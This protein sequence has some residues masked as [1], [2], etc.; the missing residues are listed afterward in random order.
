MECCNGN[1]EKPLWHHLLAPRDSILYWSW[2]LAETND[3]KALAL[4]E[5]VAEHIG[6]AMLRS[7]ADVEALLQLDAIAEEEPLPTSHEYGSAGYCLEGCRPLSAGAPPCA[8]EFRNMLQTGSQY[9]R[10]SG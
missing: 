4:L 9:L 3:A 5:R 8:C 7:D 2:T 10:A 6:A 1:K